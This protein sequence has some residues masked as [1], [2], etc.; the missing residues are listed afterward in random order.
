MDIPDKSQKKLNCEAEMHSL[1][2]GRLAFLAEWLTSLM[3]VTDPHHGIAV[4]APMTAM[5][6]SSGQDLA[7]GILSCGHGSCRGI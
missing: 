6:W 4:G 1:D 3:K 2:P 5:F 7:V